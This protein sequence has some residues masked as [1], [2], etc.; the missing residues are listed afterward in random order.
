MEKKVSAH[1]HRNRH[2]NSTAISSCGRAATVPAGSV[3]A[4]RVLCPA[5]PLLC[6]LLF[7]HACRLRRLGGFASR[8]GQRFWYDQAEATSHFLT[9]HLHPPPC[10]SPSPPTSNAQ[11]HFFT[12][13]PPSHQRLLPSQ[14]IGARP[15][16]SSLARATVGSL[17][18]LGIHRANER[19][20]RRLTPQNTVETLV[21]TRLCMSLFMCLPYRF[22]H[23][24]N[25][26]F[27]TLSANFNPLTVLL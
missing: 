1:R 11:H 23:Y 26:R 22:M 4:C 20:C 15:L 2:R 17:T 21:G 6:L 3:L 8:H 24:P 16:P 9:C 18:R 5:S 13:R 25:S 10:I 14:S 7:I 19:A 27:Y 12:N